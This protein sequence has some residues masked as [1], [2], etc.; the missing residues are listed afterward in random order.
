MTARDSVPGERRRDARPGDGAGKST[1]RLKAAT[2]GFWLS[3]ALF[4][5][6]TAALALA[7]RR[8][9]TATLTP[10][11]TAVIV[12]TYFLFPTAVVLTFWLMRRGTRSS[13]ALVAGIVGSV[14]AVALATG[15][16][17]NCSGTGTPVLT[18]IAW[19]GELFF[20]TAAMPFG[21]VPGC[22][23]EPPLSLGIAQVMALGVL[24]VAA[25]K[26][27]LR[28]SENVVQ[29]LRIRRATNLVLVV[30]AGDRAAYAEAVACACE[31]ET[32]TVSI[33]EDIVGK[34]VAPR[35][36]VLH[37]SGQLGTPDL[38]RSLLGRKTETN[39]RAVHL[40]DPDTTTNLHHYDAVRDAVADA[41]SVR[42]IR[43]LVRIDNPWAAE[44]WRRGALKTDGWIVD[45]LS[46]HETT[47]YEVLRQIMAERHDHL[48]VCG[49]GLLALAVCEV[50][51]Q[52]RREIDAI[53]AALKK[54]APT[55]AAPTDQDAPTP[56]ERVPAVTLLGPGARALG[57]N[58]TVHQVRFG[59]PE[60]DFAVDESPLTRDA[61][62]RLAGKETSPVIVFTEPEE[63]LPVELAARHE[64]WAIFAYQPGATGVADRALVGTL[65]TFGL[66]LRHAADEPADEWERMARRVH[67]VYFAQYGHEGGPAA[68]PWSQLDPFY[69]ESNLRLVTNLVRSAQDAGL[70]WGAPEGA[71]AGSGTLTEDQ[72]VALAQAEHE[73]WRA[74]LQ[75]HGW[76]PGAVR[77]NARKIHP[78]LLPWDILAEADRQKA[79]TSVLTSLAMLE[80]FGFVPHQ[81]TGWR[82][83]QDYERS[84]EVT[85]TR[86]D[87]P[88]TWT[89]QDGQPLNAAAGDWLVTGPDGTQWTIADDKLHATYRQVDANVWRRHGVLRARPAVA[90]EI[91]RS[92]EGR[93]LAGHGDWVVQE[94]DGN[95]WTVP[96]EHFAAHY[97]EVERTTPSVPAT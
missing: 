77:D 48:I 15:A 64:N 24:S 92:H 61:V 34:Q 62:E 53:A 55:E 54:A 40:V 83:W 8:L 2:A 30:G 43:A 84:G 87:R 38:F 81:T 14:S 91:V 68:K 9:S 66:A 41:T 4:V 46:S 39:L 23:A 65:R 25:V 58:H 3:V 73:S 94:T 20:G 1:S 21:Q 52:L 45:A 60:S 63:T 51:S 56:Q 82:R 80:S 35:E 50:T 37:L 13:I 19:V 79:R 26:L 28:F 18:Q 76:K 47:A 86:L 27:V 72:I 75:R 59:N 74:F 33:G 67:E 29:R 96:A 32:L 36:G 11:W 17:W 71:P 5:A 57:E 97:R 69:R 85:A 12:L 42:P 70:S 49:D 89:T 10:L 6:T 78:A 93:V 90:G 22:P 16:Y 44:E 95:M 88:I 7:E 31:P